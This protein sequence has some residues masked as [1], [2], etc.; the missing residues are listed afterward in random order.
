MMEKIDY[1]DF[2]DFMLSNKELAKHF[3]E[4]HVFPIIYDLEQDDYFGTEGF[5]KR[6]A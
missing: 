6:F 5:N 2:L 3:L 1:E 4:E